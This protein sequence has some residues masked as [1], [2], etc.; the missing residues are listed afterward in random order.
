MDNML[1]V[2]TGLDVLPLL[3]AV[4]T[5]PLLWNTDTVRT[6]HPGSV[7][8]Q[9]SDILLYFQAPAHVFEQ[10]GMVV[11][12]EHECLPRP[13]WWALPEAR[14]LIFGLMSRVGATRL[15]RCMITKLGPDCEIPPHTDS[16]SQ[17]QYYLRHHI[18]LCSPP[19]CVFRVEDDEVAMQPGSCWW[20][21]NG[22]EHSV[23]NGGPTERIALIVDVHVPLLMREGL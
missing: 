9:V 11:D 4:S 10:G 22:R 16:P 5:Q 6:A 23:Y 14:P 18:T 13:A 15:G 1:C 20:V 12:D 19:A 21:N 8:K 7:H 3:Y 17:T 2:T